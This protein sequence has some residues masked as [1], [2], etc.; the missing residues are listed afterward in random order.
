MPKITLDRKMYK[1]AALKRMSFS[2]YLETLDPT[3]EGS[4]LDAFERQLKERGIITKTDYGKGINASIVGEAFYRTED[5]D[6]LFPEFV[7]RT[8]REVLVEDVMLSSLIGIYTTINGASYKTVYADDDPDN[9]SLK[10]VTEAAHL[11]KARLR[12]RDQEVKIY[13]YGRM[14]E[15]S[16]EVIRRMT[17]DMLALHIRRF[18]MQAAKDHV[19]EIID[20]VIDGD[21]NDN[22]A[23]S[24]N[25]TTLDSDASAGTLTAKGWLKFLMQ[26]EEF[27]C[28]TLIA[29][30]E[31]FLQ[32]LLTD[33]GT[34]TAADV[35]RLLSQGATTGVSITAPQ[36]PGGSVKL[37]WHSDVDEL[38]VVG[39]NN[40][41]AIEKVTEAGSEI[42]EADRFITNQTEVL[43]ISEN[44][45]YS[46]IFSEATKVL[47][48][49]A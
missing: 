36:M 6:I 18:G 27:P 7:N 29:D 47:D 26:F 41:F 22:A 19:S 9:Q 20:V 24:Y 25:L 44:S 11:P 30:Q 45:G 4:P 8:V 10:R 21:G 48:I 42:Q 32:I 46:K 43:T 2:Q 15:A 49:N 40:Q 17:I 34:F 39:I 3:P 16:Y 37:F 31:A 1:E 35:L 5:N 38:N 14:I 28:N 23:E 13:K 12:I 33:L